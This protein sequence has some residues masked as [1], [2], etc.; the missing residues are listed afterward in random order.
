MILSLDTARPGKPDNATVIV[1]GPS[2][3]NVERCNWVKVSK[4]TKAMMAFVLLA[5]S[6]Q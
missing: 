3:D 2:G 1:L 5:K 6:M 4:K